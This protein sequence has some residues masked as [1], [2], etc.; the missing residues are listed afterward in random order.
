MTQK[1]IVRVSVSGKIAPTRLPRQGAV[2]V[3]VTIGG[4]IG[5]TEPGGLPQ[6]QTITIAINRH[7][8]VDRR[9]LPLCSVRRIDPSTTRDALATCRS[10]LIGEGS[11]S[12]DVKLPEQSPFPSEGKI[13]AF[14]GRMGGR[15]AILAHI[16]GTHPVPTSYVLPFLIHSSKGTFGTVLEAS[17]P[18]VTGSWGYVTGVSMTLARRFT[19]RG[20]KRSYLAAG[21]PAPPGFRGAFFPLIR[22][23]FAFAGG[24]TLTSVLNRRCTVK[25]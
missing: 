11:F 19:F 1:G 14:N 15:P 23:G 16:Y 8:R 24:V 18:H 12:A 3:A 6:L 10:S 2:P 5:S 9:G 25:G 22:A 21:C 17:L 4:K 13:L 7:G 20:H